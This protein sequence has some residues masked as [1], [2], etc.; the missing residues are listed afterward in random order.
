M[1]K[2][3]GICTMQNSSVR[4]KNS[5]SGITLIALIITI[6]VL[7]ILAGV[8]ISMALGDNGIITRSQYAKERH[9][10]GTAKEIIELKVANLE[11]Q[12]IAENNK[13][14]QLQYIANGLWP[15]VDSEIEYV[16]VS[17]RVA[18]TSSYITIG[19][20]IDTIFVKLK[21]YKYEFEI[22]RS[23]KIVSAKDTETKEKVE[24]DSDIDTG[25]DNT[26][27]VDTT[28]PTVVVT[29]EDYYEEDTLKVNVEAT[30]KESGIP[31]NAIYNY[32]LTVY[33]S[34]FPSEPTYSGTE[35][36]FVFTQDTGITGIISYD[37]KVTVADAAGNVGAGYL[38][39]AD[40]Y[41]EC[42]VAGTPV[43]T[44]EGLRNIEDLKVGDIV[45][46]YNLETQK[47]EEKE[48]VHTIESE[49]NVLVNITL[50]NGEKLQNTP[51]HP[52]Y[53][54]EKGWIEAENLKAGD[55]LLTQENGKVKIAKVE[56]ETL[57]EP[58]K[59]Y[60][61]E[62]ADNHNYFVG[63]SKI[64][65]HNIKCVFPDSEIEVSLD[66][67]YILAKD[68]KVGDN[69]VYYNFE[70]QQKEIGKVVKTYIHEDA[71]DFVTYRFE[72]DT[73]LRVTDYHPIYTK[74]GW[75]SYTQYKGYE[76][77]QVGD[78]VQTEDGWK[79]ITDIEK[80]TGLEDCY[81]FAVET[82]D[83]ESANNYYANDVLV[84]STLTK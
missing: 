67:D 24:D 80:W 17:T 51:L 21:A 82:A 26:G 47:A 57:K 65:V 46:T 31:E 19:D 39:G 71:T 50:E 27:V 49:D 66:G 5:T 28:P 79:K 70:T 2:Q 38:E 16:D 84:Q 14:P 25:D 59:V 1:K 55:I 63:T 43:S 41:F 68:I 83:G 69:I 81:D 30:D 12:K 33:D 7:L 42:F 53:I 40:K 78:E 3:N 72:D 20:S 54:S 23:G 6:I 48:I 9:E 58:V 60:N 29:Q 44:V 45:L 13:D 62:T 15:E 56:I 75:K 74:E 52:Y 4:I 10:Y 77:P 34:D 35:S 76:V 36:T 22:S 18:T 37:V 61:I 8:S 73:V 64:L 11:M 32:Y